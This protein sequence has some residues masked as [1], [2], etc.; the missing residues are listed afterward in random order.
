MTPELM[1]R[2][3][4]LL[5]EGKTIIDYLYQHQKEISGEMKEYMNN[6]LN[7]VVLLTDTINDQEQ[8]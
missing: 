7:E 5:G 4:H 1:V 3:V 2:V 8:D 6:W